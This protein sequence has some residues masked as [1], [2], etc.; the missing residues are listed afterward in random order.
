RA[1]HGDEDLFLVRVEVTSSLRAGR[2]APHACARFGELSL[3]GQHRVPPRLLTR[4]RLAL[5]P[6][7]SVRVHDVVRHEATIP[8]AA[9]PPSPG[10][11]HCRP[12]S[13]R[14]DSSSRSRSVSTAP[15]SGRSFRWGS[16]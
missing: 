10:P 8:S 12:E 15:T 11:L 5:L 14:S 16:S 3:L 9:W 6:L 7:E 2:V 1:A 4:R 13:G